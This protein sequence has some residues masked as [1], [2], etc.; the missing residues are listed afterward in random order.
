[1]HSFTYVSWPL[2]VEPLEYQF[3]KSR[4]ALSRFSKQDKQTFTS[5]MLHD[6]TPLTSKHSCT[7]RSTMVYQIIKMV[8]SW[9]LLFNDRP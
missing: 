2:I 3:K 4:K 5:P 8:Q 9:Y 7:S 6:C 1:M